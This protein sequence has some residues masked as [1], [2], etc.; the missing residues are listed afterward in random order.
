MSVV[1]DKRL[2]K[3]C[4][5]KSDFPK[6]CLRLTSYMWDTPFNESSPKPWCWHPK[7]TVFVVDEKEGD[8]CEDD[9]KEG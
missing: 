4:N 6:R 7:R 5:Y 8:E 1:L 3:D 2:C 9:Y